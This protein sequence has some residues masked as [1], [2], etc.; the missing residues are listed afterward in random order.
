MLMA[1]GPFVKPS[2]KGSLH[3]N[4]AWHVRQTASWVSTE[5]YGLGKC[6]VWVFM[7]IPPLADQCKNCGN[8]SLQ[9][10]DLRCFSL[11]FPQFPQPS[12]GKHVMLWFLPH[13]ILFGTPNKSKAPIFQSQLRESDGDDGATETS[14]AVLRIRSHI[15]HAPAKNICWCPRQHE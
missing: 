14:R 9:H 15:G 5:S 13:T 7:S 11:I 2:H 1:S 10:N 8:H 4:L 12:T 3:W 6:S